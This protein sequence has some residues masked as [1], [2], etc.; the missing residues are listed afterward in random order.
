MHAETLRRWL[1]LRKVP[2]EFLNYERVL[3]YVKF[4][5]A[6]HFLARG[7]DLGELRFR[8]GSMMLKLFR[9]IP[10]G[11]LESLFPNSEVRMRPIDKLTLGVPALASGLVVLF[12]KLGA[13]LGLVFLFLGF[14]L[15]LRDT[16]PDF[17]HAALALLAGGRRRGERRIGCRAGRPRGPLAIA[18]QLGPVA[19]RTG[20][21]PLRRRRLRCHPGPVMCQPGHRVPV[22]RAR[23]LLSGHRS[24]SAHSSGNL[25]P[26]TRQACGALMIGVTYSSCPNPAV[27]VVAPVVAG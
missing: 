16:E 11:D 24:P 25:R 9:N 8:P 12:T 22:H 10:Q 14:H 21:F 7:R 5:P 18:P 2:I 26:T 20:P 15:G 19:A 17:D 13:A 4:K 1:G 3:V 27:P 6:E 23:R